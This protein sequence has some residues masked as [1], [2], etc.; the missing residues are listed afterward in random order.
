MLSNDHTAARPRAKDT[1]TRRCVG[2]D[3]AGHAPAEQIR[4]ASALRA[5]MKSGVVYG[6]T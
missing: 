6:V 5:T 2:Q 3:Y 4:A 1:N